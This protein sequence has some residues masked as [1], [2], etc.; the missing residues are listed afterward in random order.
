MRKCIVRPLL[1]LLAAAALTVPA[2]AQNRSVPPRQ[3]VQR[4]ISA[5]RLVRLTQALDLTEDQTA[6]VYPALNRI[7]KSKQEIQ[8]DL[9]EDVLALR[10]MS[11]DPAAKDADL[12]AVLVRMRDNRARIMDLDKEA[13][14]FLAGILTVRQKALYEIFQIDFLRGLNETMNQARQRMGRPGMAP[15]APPVKE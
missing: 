10:A 2:A 15:A 12:M 8:K 11:Q 6:K 4:N 14:A 9:S 3:R 13:D 1:A 7:E 5:L